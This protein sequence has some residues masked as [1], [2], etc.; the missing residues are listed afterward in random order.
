MSL[1]PVATRWFELLVPRGELVAAME[2]LAHTGAVELEM[3]AH[4]VTPSRLTLDDLESRLQSCA[5]LSRRYQAYWPAPASRAAVPAAPPAQVLDAALARLHAWARDADAPIARLQALDHEHGDLLLLR[6]L[7][8]S[9]AARTPSP[10]RLALAG[11]M[12][13]V[14]LW[15]LPPEHRPAPP[16]PAV[17]QRIVEAAG[18]TFVLAVGPAGEMPALEQR[19]HALKA[20]RIELPR[21]L[22]SDAAEAPA[23]IGARL[24]DLENERRALRTRLDALSADHDLPGAI[25]DVQRLAWFT[26]HARTLPV[27]DHF[28]WVTGWTS[29]PDGGELAAAL[30]AAG[31]PHAIHLI[32]PP[33][34]LQPPMM[35]RNPPWARGFELFARLL[36]T[37]AAH[38]ADPTRI[39]AIMAPL[40]FGFMFSDVG[41]GLVL[42]VAGL[43]LR[44]RLP[45]L[46][47]LVPGGAMA[48]V[49]GLLF[50]SVFSREDLLPALW[51][52]PMEEPVTLLEVGL[53]A[54]AVI[55]GL[56]L[57][58]DAVQEHWHGAGVRWWRSRAGLVAAY[59]SLLA[60]PLLPA[61]GWGIAAGV[62]WCLLG[63]A[64]PARGRRLSAL[65]G[66]VAEVLETLLQ[67]VVNTI[68]FA[69]V[70][71]FALAHAGLSAAIAGIADGLRST[72]A[73]GLVMVIGNVVVIVLEGLVVSIQTTRLVLFEFFIRFL[74]TG[75]RPFRP[76]P[77][78]GPSDIRRQERAS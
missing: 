36:G 65:G 63:E 50:G 32:T 57:A 75:G 28:G 41:Q 38:E 1:R 7:L 15:V 13:G 23:V 69:R 4:A 64:V 40:L 52:R 60:T 74:R 54:G 18:H 8:A 10:A 47:L 58:L 48:M 39:V 26:S 11:P 34:G 68:S 51:L 72:L 35:F 25:G 24:T 71:A 55:V 31:I 37:P 46:G 27:S 9:R 67:L 30:E 29:D 59:A 14:A 21:W 78:P 73:A 6:E 49:F 77:A 5:E 33:A 44:R 45:P 61:A 62:T 66:A 19:M 3:R 20:R 56:G 2:A 53:A 70:G 43:A 76:L 22:P 12:L 42:V 16:P 17:V